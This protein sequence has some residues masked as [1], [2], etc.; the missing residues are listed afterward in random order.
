MKQIRYILL[1]LLP[2]FSSC[3]EDRSG[4]FY[5]L[6][7]DRVW[8][9]EVMKQKY[10]WYDQLPEKKENDYFTQPEA[11]F[12]SLL[13]KN[14]LDGKGDSYSYMETIEAEEAS[15]RA[16]TLNRASTYGMEFELVR[17]PLNKSTHTFARILY[18]IPDSPADKA[19]IKR[20]DWISEIDNKTVTTN[21]YKQMIAGGNINLTREIIHTDNEGNRNWQAVDTL[22]LSPSVAMNISPFYLDSVYHIGGQRI[23]YFVYNEFATGPQNNASDTAYEEQ[24]INIFTKF[25]SQN[26]DAFI[27][28]LR[29]NPGGFLSCAQVLGSLLAPADE[30]GKGFVK[31]EFNDRTEPQAIE[32]PFMEK[33]AT[34]N[35][36]LNKIYI[37][38]TQ[39]TAS[40]SEALINGLKPYMG[41]ENVILIGEKTEGKNVAMSS[42]QDER[43][44]YILWPVVAYVS[45]AEGEG[46]YSKG[47]EP[48]Y[49]LNERA[50][51]SPWYPLGDVREYYLKNT[52]SLITE[53]FMPDLRKTDDGGQEDNV[54]SVI[55]TISA[56]TRQGNR[57]E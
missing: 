43:F 26:P 24:M 27:L 34:Q 22:S 2:I 40:A 19:G 15:T 31:L 30:L 20:G 51:I 10:L 44:N 28:D 54:K 11:F 39:Y 18:V 57:F 52:L 1:L 37:L 45:N 38:T 12:K 36:N 50:L 41:E 46:N 7:E 3:G 56:K 33:Y 53:G 32:Y 49:T 23:A 8:I 4:E 9:E 6:I 29:Y 16:I 5:A 35:M 55:S 47:F 48:L 14:A 17:D 42:Y 25:K 21:N 13:Y